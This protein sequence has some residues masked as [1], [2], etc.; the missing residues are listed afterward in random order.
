MHKRLNEIT[1]PSKSTDAEKAK[2][3][4]LRTTPRGRGLVKS[5]VVKQTTIFQSKRTNPQRSK[6]RWAMYDLYRLRL[7]RE[8]QIGCDP[9]YLNT[10]WPRNR[11]VLSAQWKLD[12]KAWDKAHQKPTA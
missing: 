10:I 9:K 5:I 1:K 12:A 7:E 8:R 6:K 4:A 3:E 2:W 11:A